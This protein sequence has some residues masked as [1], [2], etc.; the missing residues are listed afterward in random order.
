MKARK[1]PVVVDVFLY[2]REENITD[3]VSWVE[4]VTGKHN[5]QSLIYDP[6]T[7]EWY[8]K[9]LEGNMLIT[10]GDYVICGVNKE[11]YPC[12]PDIFKKT[13]DILE[14]FMDVVLGVLDKN[15]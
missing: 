14:D 15:E 2:Q 13:Y 4:E 7:N 8:C 11:I 12:K 9:T 5:S 10:K 3:F 1:K 6:V